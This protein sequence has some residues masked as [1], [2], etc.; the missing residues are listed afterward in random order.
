MELA[1]AQEHEA[2]TQLS[3]NQ[4]E[5]AN[6]TLEASRLRKQ[7]DETRKELVEEQMETSSLQKQLDKMRQVRQL[8]EGTYSKIRR[9]LTDY[10]L[11]GAG[12]I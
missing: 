1:L 4:K 3:E 5:L 9:A 12:R 11:A 7:L 2:R 6:K 8:L 10:A